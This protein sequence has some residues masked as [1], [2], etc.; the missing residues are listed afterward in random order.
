MKTCKDCGITKDL[1]EFY[2]NPGSRDGHRSNCA[3][4]HSLKIQVA[5]A[6]RLGNHVEVAVDKEPV[7]N[8]LTT[9]EIAQA[10]SDF[11]RDH[12]YLVR[13]LEDSH[14]TP[15]ELRNQEKGL[16]QKSAG[17]DDLTPEEYKAAWN[18]DRGIA[19]SE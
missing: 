15:Q 10:Y 9:D 16:P 3:A 12:R 8:R 5:R 11:R 18:F 6:K 13:I 19:Q 7:S 14:K 2:K 1:G 4:C 17:L